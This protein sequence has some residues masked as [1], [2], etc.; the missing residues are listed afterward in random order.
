[1]LDLR[2]RPDAGLLGE[3]RAPRARRRRRVGR[4]RP[5]RPGAG[6]TAEAIA[7]R[8]A[9]RDRGA[10]QRTSATA[11][12][13][14]AGLPCRGYAGADP[15]AAP[16]PAG[17]RP[18]PPHAHP[19]PDARRPRRDADARAAARSDEPLLDYLFGKDSG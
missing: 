19:Q 8:A 3:L 11:A 14:D 13:P 4:R 15:V 17:R 2:D 10:P 12:T 1:M 16:R 7:P 9:R 5:A 6:R 18:P